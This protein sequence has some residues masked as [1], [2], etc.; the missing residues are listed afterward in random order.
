[1]K[2]WAICRLGDYENDGTLVPK[3]SVYHCNFRIWSK[4]GLNWCFGQ[5][6]SNQIAA[7]QADP[8]I[9]ILPDASLDMAWSAVPAGTRNAVTNKLS[10]AGLS[11]VDWKAN[12]SIRQCLVNLLKQIQP[13][14]TTI[15]DSDVADQEG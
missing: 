1:M 13:A 12:W 7:M 8:D 11:T 10:S 2:R 4:A 6:G 3:F 5:I 15:E 9:F 14:L